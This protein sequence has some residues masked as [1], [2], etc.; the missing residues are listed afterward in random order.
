[1]ISLSNL[2]K[3]S[4][5]VP[6]DDKKVIHV[7]KSPLPVLKVEHAVKPDDEERSKKKDEEESKALEEIN[8]LKDK[9]LKD[10]EE[11]A[12]SQIKQA[13]EE[14][15]SMKEQAEKEINTWWEDRRK[16]DDL[17]IEEA[18]SSGFEQGYQEGTEKA[19]EA[20]REE[21]EKQLQEARSI[22]ENAQVQKKQIIQEAEPFLIELS[23][24]ISKKIINHQLTISQDWVI[25]LIKKVLTRKREKG[26]ITLCVSPPHFSYIQDARGELAL[27]VDSQADLQILPDG[28]VEDHGCVIR[29]S[30]GSIDA[31]I[32][33]QLTEIKN[34][35][36]QIALRSQEDDQHD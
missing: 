26:L 6:V 2:I 24:E 31:R 8:V 27:A 15:A 36:Y 13:M 19:E 10:A 35:L 4:R 17:H 22:L 14:T 5:Y 18:K 20:V 11:Y 1:M 3:Y 25:E 16:S 32:D 30:L 9:I 23:C 21:Y 33:T 34:A 28:T 12:E 29:S 7:I